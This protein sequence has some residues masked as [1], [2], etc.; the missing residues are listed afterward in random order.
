MSHLSFYNFG[1][2]HQ[3]GPFKGDLSGSTVWPQVSGFQKLVIMT[4]CGIL[5]I[6]EHSVVN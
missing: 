4:I 2:L 1:N 6:F 5:G 3:F